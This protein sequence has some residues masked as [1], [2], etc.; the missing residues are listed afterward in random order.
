[1][2][3]GPALVIDRD[4]AI[5]SI[6][7][8]C[9]DLDAAAAATF[10]DQVPVVN[11]A[12]VQAMAQVLAVLAEQASGQESRDFGRSRRLTEQQS[13]L[14][15]EIHEMKRLFPDGTANPGYPLEKERALL[16]AL[17]RGDDAGSRRMLNELLG[18]VFFTSGSCF[19]L[20]KFKAME[21]MVLLSRAVI[22]TGGLE[23][24]VLEANYRL[25]RR[26][27]DAE[28]Q[29]ELTDLLNMAI[30][31]FSKLAFTV[32][33]VRHAAAMRRA[34]RHIREHYTGNL[35]LAQT[36][37]AAGLSAAYFS[38]VF[39]AEMGESFS[40]YVNRIRIER[41]AQ[42]LISTDNTLA[43]VAGACGFEDQSWFTKVFN[44]RMGVPPGRYREGG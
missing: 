37:C 27:Q 23:A 16:D 31:R 13:R 3:C 29:E 14:S 42:L 6:Q 18:A 1:M 38:S 30:E 4:E 12:R 32:R 20:I 19:E 41:A 36:A 11:P 17:R 39:K 34:E 2:V 15:E 40:E 43:E 26:I 24:A 9:P 21:L 25:M 44:R 7:E 8:A 22:E 28:D 35:T 10:A 33:P 5:A